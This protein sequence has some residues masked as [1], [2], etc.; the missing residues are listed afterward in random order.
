MIAQ[1]DWFSFVCTALFPNFL[2]GALTGNFLVLV[3]DDADKG[4]E[5]YFSSSVTS[6]FR[7][8]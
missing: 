8:G 3:I 4:R 2:F 5:M 7:L 1:I 6:L